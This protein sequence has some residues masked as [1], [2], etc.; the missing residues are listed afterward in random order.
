MPQLVFEPLPGPV[1][2][3]FDSL[4]ALKTFDVSNNKLNGSRACIEIDSAQ[5]TLSVL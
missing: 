4:P 5:L 3:N 2:D 1:G